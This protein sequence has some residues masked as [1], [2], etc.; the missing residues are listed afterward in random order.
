MSN[1]NYEIVSF[2]NEYNLLMSAM[3]VSVSKHIMNE[4]F[5]V[6]WANDYY[7]KKIGYSRREYEQFFQNSVKNYYK[8]YNGIYQQISESVMNALKNKEAG[9]D[10]ICR[11]PIK[12]GDMI[13]IKIRGMFTDEVYEGNKVIYSVFTDITDLIQREKEKAVTYDKLPGFI[14]KFRIKKNREFQLLESNGRFHDFFGKDISPERLE[15]SYLTT[16][17]AVE[18]GYYK[19]RN[20]MALQFEASSV[21]NAGEVCWFQISGEYIGDMDHDPIYLFV[22]ID[23]TEQKKDREEIEKLAFVDPVT[24]GYNR[25]RFD[26]EMK[27]ILNNASGNQFFFVSLNIDKFKLVNDTWGIEKGD[28]LLRY[29]SNTFIHEMK[30]NECFGRFAADQFISLLWGGSKEDISERIKK[31]VRK[32]NRFNDEIEN[33]Y[34]LNFKIGVYQVDD[35]SLQFATM[36]DRANIAIKKAKYSSENQM[37]S[38]SFYTNS[39]RL[40]LM[41]EKD[42]ENKLDIA[43]KNNDF[44]VYLQPKVSVDT[45]E[46]AGAEA[47]VRWLDPEEGLLFPDRFIPI[48]ENNGSIVKLDLY[49]FEKVC[50]TIRKWIDNGYDPIPISVNMSRVHIGNAQFMEPYEKIRKKYGIPTQYIEFELTETMIFDNF[51]VLKNVIDMIH[52]A[53]YTCSMDDFGSGYSS[54]NTLREMEFDCL[55]LDRTFFSF[56]NDTRGEEIIKS[57]LSMAHKLKMSSVAEGVETCQQAAFLERTD[58]NLIQGYIYSKPIPVVEFERM[59]YG[60]EI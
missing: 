2:D 26:I 32:I 6:I 31:I 23:I 60:K 37:V 44:V 1:S 58:C 52:K 36:Y 50:I 34:F 16:E 46:I 21:S 14:V 38:I 20:R 41:K 4:D 42:I 53:G 13:W 12:N 57:V 35:T 15:I 39:D 40:K 33:K 5:T 49:V 11:M 47:L 17:E 3:D 8:N 45:K 56:E 54:L 48:L 24:N 55:K 28:R 59:K 22:F 30:E 27:K 43:L 19:M 9:Y 10:C 25:N 18:T 51:D 29:V 7:Y